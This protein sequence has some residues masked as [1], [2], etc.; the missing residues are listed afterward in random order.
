MRNKLNLSKNLDKAG[1]ILGITC[2]IHCLLLPIILATLPFVSFLAFMREPIAESIMII[3]AIFN[4]ILAVTLNFSRHKNLILPSLFISG[5]ILLLLNFLAHNFVAKNEY[6]IT[7][8]AFLI[9]V[10]HFINHRL[11]ES[12]PQCHHE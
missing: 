4:A 11:C 1:V 5:I 7:L 6:V 12:C 10:G 3:F 2:M 9:G 8:G